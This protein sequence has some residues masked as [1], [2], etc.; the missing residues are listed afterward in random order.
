MNLIINLKE[1]QRK[2]LSSPYEDGLIDLMIGTIF[3]LTAVNVIFKGSSYFFIPL[4]II[5]IVLLL[6]AKKYIT[7]PRMGVVI[8]GRS[9]KR[10]ML[11]VYIIIAFSIIFNVIFEYMTRYGYYAGTRNILSAQTIF[12]TKAMIVFVL[13]AYFINFKR[14]YIYGIL[15]AMTIPISKILQ[16]KNIISDNREGLLFPGLIIMIAGIVIFIRF[17]KKYPLPIEEV[18]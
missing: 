11:P 12:A 3:S 16:L 13:I 17:I 10:R 2:I 9:E 6:F 7:A 8:I 1:I 18:Q 4:I 5:P 15:F 14:L